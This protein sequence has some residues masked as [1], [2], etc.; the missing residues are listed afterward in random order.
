MSIATELIRLQGAKADL[1][2][3]IEA[4]GVTVPSSTLLDGY[5]SL[6]DQISGG[7]Q[8]EQD[9]IDF[10]ERDITSITIPDG[11]SKIGEYA[12]AGFTTNT[13]LTSI[14]IPDSVTAIDNYAF[15]DSTKLQSITIPD[16]VTTIGTSAFQNCTGIRGTFTLPSG[17]TTINPNTLKNCSNIT[18]ITIPDDVT[19]IGNAAFSGCNSLTS[20]TIPN[21]VITIDGSAFQ[22]CNSLTSITIPDSVTF[23]GMYCFSGCSSLTYMT[24][25]ATTPP[26]LQNVN[27][28]N[29]TNDCPIYV[30]AESV[31][32]Y[33]TA[34]GWNSIASRIQGYEVGE[35]SEGDNTPDNFA[36]FGVKFNP[37]DVQDKEIMFIDE[38][39]NVYQI[40]VHNNKVILVYDYGHNEIEFVPGDDVEIWFSDYGI[41]VLPYFDATNMNFIPFTLTAYY[42]EK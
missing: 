9:L 10:I 3:S 19:L 7:G 8:A 25:K 37:D 39:E 30:P 36:L 33:K 32:A 1:K 34:S 31:A 24:I 27:A 12:F 29:N 21:S 13:N 42:I 23:I 40:Y 26:T 38:N 41:T 17:I 16:S 28:F 5:S 20:I 15:F 2:I 35:L 22:G 6:V 4:K 14:T 11:T 18:S